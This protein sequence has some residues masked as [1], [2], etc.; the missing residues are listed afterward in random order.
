MAPS[1][2]IIRLKYISHN[3]LLT[4]CP[5]HHFLLYLI[6]QSLSDIGHTT[7]AFYALSLLILTSREVWWL[8]GAV[9]CVSR[10]GRGFTTSRTPFRQ[11]YQMSTTQHPGKV[12]MADWVMYTKWHLAKSSLCSAPAA[13]AQCSRTSCLVTSLTPVTCSTSSGAIGCEPPLAPFRVPLSR[14]SSVATTYSHRRVGHFSRQV[15][16]THTAYLHSRQWRT[17]GGGLGCSNPPPRNSEDIGVVLDRMSKKN[18][19][20]DFLLQFTVFSYGCNLL[21]KGYF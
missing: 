2:Q 19:R 20:L 5:A 11:L 13:P 15:G 14:F 12:W 6:A 10:V 9:L 7:H 21:N 8:V 17:E 18:R 16:L 1:L 3:P 4:T